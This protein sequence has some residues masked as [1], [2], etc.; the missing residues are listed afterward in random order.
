MGLPAHSPLGFKHSAGPFRLL[1]GKGRLSGTLSCP[2]GR[3]WS[4]RASQKAGGG[5]APPEEGCSASLS[6][7]QREQLRFRQDHSNELERLQIFEA[8]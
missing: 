4:S 2:V 6:Q 1:S 3:M 5:G 8:M 7:V